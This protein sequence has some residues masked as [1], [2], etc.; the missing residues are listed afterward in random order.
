MLIYQKIKGIIVKILNKANFDVI[1]PTGFCIFNMEIRQLNT[2][3]FMVL[4]FHL[5]LVVAPLQNC[6]YFSVVLLIG[7]RTMKFILHPTSLTLPLT[8]RRRKGKKKE[9][10][11]SRVAS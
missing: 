1:F 7:F 6:Y 3:M 10:C 9:G 8:L 11:L 4:M 5:L 2:I